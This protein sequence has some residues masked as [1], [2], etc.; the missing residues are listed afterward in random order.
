MSKKYH[1]AIITNDLFLASFLHSLGCTLTA[2]ERNERRRV[3]FVFTGERV[4]ELREAY[5]TG[6]VSLDMNAFRESMQLI[7]KKMD[8]ALASPLSNGSTTPY[9]RSLFHARHFTTQP[10]Q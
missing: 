5:R 4:R 2:V 3:S 8:E 1:S 6:K 7:R 10:Q 9:E